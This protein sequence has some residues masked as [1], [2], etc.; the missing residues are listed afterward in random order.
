MPSCPVHRSAPGA[1]GENEAQEG[2]VKPPRH[3]LLTSEH[4]GARSRFCENSAQCA[5]NLHSDQSPLP[6]SVMVCLPPSSWLVMVTLPEYVVF[7][8]VGSKVT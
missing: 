1:R 7:A 4:S 5:L 3:N 6:I 2:A 8:F